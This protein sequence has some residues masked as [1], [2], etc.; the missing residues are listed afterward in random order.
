MLVLVSEPPCYVSARKLLGIG[1]TRGTCPDQTRP[2]PSAVPLATP[3]RNPPFVFRDF[4]RRQHSL[5]RWAPAGHCRVQSSLASSL[6]LS[7]RRKGWGDNGSPARDIEHGNGGTNQSH[8]QIYVITRAP[9]HPSTVIILRCPSKP[10]RSFFLLYFQFASTGTRQLRRS[11]Q[12]AQSA[13]IRHPV[14]FR[15]FSLQQQRSTSSP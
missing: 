13:N 3:L 9:R 11:T 14:A 5:G 8:S 6:V 7:R 10:F 4:L 12:C 1:G 2:W 15:L